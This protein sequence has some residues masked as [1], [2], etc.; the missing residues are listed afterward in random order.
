MVVGERVSL[1]NDFPYLGV[2]AAIRPQILTHH[3]GYTQAGISLSLLLLHVKLY[4]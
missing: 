1:R 4:L 3:L 2:T